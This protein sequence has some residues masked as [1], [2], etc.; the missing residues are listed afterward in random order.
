MRAICGAWLAA[1]AVAGTICRAETQY[2]YELTIERDGVEVRSGPSLDFYVTDRLSSGEGIEVYRREPGGWL[3]I[4]PPD[5]SFSLVKRSRLKPSGRNVATV[6][7][8]GTTC[9]VGSL[10]ADTDQNAT[11]VLL[12]A[13]E[14]VEL[15]EP[16]RKDQPTQSD[17]T[18]ETWVR[19]WPPAGEFR[20][21]RADDLQEVDR[22]ESPGHEDREEP[23]N[24]DAGRAEPP[25]ASSAPSNDEKVD[26]STTSAGAAKE[27]VRVP[28]ETSVHVPP[29]KA[30]SQ[31]ETPT[32]PQAPSEP[33]RQDSHA[34]DSEW[35]ERTDSEQADGE[36]VRVPSSLQPTPVAATDAGED[37]SEE[38]SETQVDQ[39]EQEKPQ[40]EK[41]DASAPVWVSRHRALQEDLDGLELELAMMV[42]Q[43]MRAWRLDSLRKRVEQAAS[44]L[45]D[46][47]QQRR[48]QDLL[49]R[50]GGFERLAD[51]ASG[52]DTDS[53]AVQPLI[54]SPP[55]RDATPATTVKYDGSGW[56]VPVHA[57]NGTVPPYALLDVQGDVMQYVSPTP[58]LNLQRYVRKRIGVF[59]Q[60]GFVRSLNK[61]HVTAERVVDLGRHLR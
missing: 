3:A 19:I 58:G 34:E 45:G 17:D 40:Q 43:E 57:T 30:P 31:L 46:P 7:R 16:L 22:S 6:L 35:R 20:W 48:A 15:L 25:G 59:G 42:S 9:R 33:V 1:L 37:S 32:E 29:E 26:T 44:R 13:G 8:D 60:Q 4:R 10:V 39:P 23:A 56:L 50:I 53:S 21:V 11:H 52:A 5:D 27:V 24:S 49:A 28:T 41:P 47:V 36:L 38:Q 14:L 51:R 12:H 61:P 54:P 2:P 18:K 55:N